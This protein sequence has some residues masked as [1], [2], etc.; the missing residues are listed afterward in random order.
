MKRWIKQQVSDA[1]A[2]ALAN[3][4]GGARGPQSEFD[5]GP[6]W[7]IFPGTLM[8]GGTVQVVGESYRQDAIERVAGPRTSSGASISHVTAQLVREPKNKHDRNAVAVLVG[9]EHCGYI[10]KEQA[11]TFGPVVDELKAMGRPATCQ[12]D[13]TG[14]W[15]QGGDD[16]GSYGLVLNIA[17]PPRLRTSRD[18]VFGSSAQLNLVGEEDH[19]EFLRS[20]LGRAKKHDFAASLAIGEAGDVEASYG[21]EPVGKLTKRMAERYLPV[22]EHVQ[23]AGWPLVCVARIKPGKTKLEVTLGLPQ[24]EELNYALIEIDEVR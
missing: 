12:A 11:P 5:V 8:S 20:R 9:G 4:T 16:V 6:N 14:G 17:Y 24:G 21:R 18:P 22:L 23:R 3:L 10:A 13:V 15:D 2:K 7:S 19:Q 1:G